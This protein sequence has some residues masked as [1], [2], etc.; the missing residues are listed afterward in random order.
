MNKIIINYLLLFFLSI[1]AFANDLEKSNKKNIAYI[2]SDMSIPFWKIMSRGIENK[3][4]EFEYNIKIYNSKNKAKEE[5]ISTV[6]A[7]KNKVDAIIVSPTNSSACVTILKLAKEANIP[8]VI[9]DIGTDS[10]EFLSFISSN[11]YKGA[12]D[13]GKI[14]AKKMKELHYENARVGIISIP[15]K[16]KNGQERTAGFLKALNEENIKGAGIEQQVNFSL[17]ETYKLSKKLINTYPDLKA[18]WLQGSDKYEGALKAIKESKKE[19]L[20]ITFD[21]EPNFLELIPSGV[22]V[23]AGMQQPFLMGEK[24]V[25]IINS[26]FHMQKVEKFIELPV[27]G[28]SKDNIQ[29]KLPIIKRNVLGLN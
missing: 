16:R 5:L 29:E 3:A 13:I 15:Q 22:L 27:L 1:C 14:L 11:N 20:L 6:N 28:I 19:I 2:V 8:V 24:A 7:I 26:Y 9:S 23:G 12:Y 21:A 4:K 18:L 10:G 25:E 17:E